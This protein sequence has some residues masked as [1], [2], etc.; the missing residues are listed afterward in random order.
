MEWRSIPHTAP[1]L[2]TNPG[3]SYHK[4]GPSA[5]WR[6][7]AAVSKGIYECCKWQKAMLWGILLVF[8]CHYLIYTS[9]FFFFFLKD[10]SVYYWK[11]RRC[12]FLCQ[13]MAAKCRGSSP[14][15]GH[16]PYIFESV[17]MIEA[18]SV[19][20]YFWQKGMSSSVVCS[21]LWYQPSHFNLLS[22]CTSLIYV[23]LCYTVLW[24]IRSFYVLSK[25]V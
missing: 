20:S 10:L 25:M 17:N 11:L 7:V 15:K 4:W 23:C 24:D 1:A 21:C 22:N 18:I 12:P 14:K 6:I 16:P 9:M 13:L 19:K 5:Y 3:F 8:Q 2:S